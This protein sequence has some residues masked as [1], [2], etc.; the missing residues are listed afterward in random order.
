MRLLLAMGAVVE[1]VPTT[2]QT[3]LSGHVSPV[4]A[5]VPIGARGAFKL[6]LKDIFGLRETG[7]RA[8]NP[9]DPSEGIPVRQAIR[10]KA[11]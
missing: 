4:R 7:P 9:L 6:L 11:S 2:C 1:G 5:V 10:T 3:P 8:D